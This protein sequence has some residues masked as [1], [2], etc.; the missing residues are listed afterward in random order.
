MDAVF[1]V[2]NLWAIPLASTGAIRSKRTYNKAW[3]DNAGITVPENIE[4]FFNFAKFIASEDPD[5]NGKKDSYIMEYSNSSFLFDFADIFRAFGCYTYNGLPIA[6]NPHKNRLENIA[7]SDNFTEAISFIGLLI[8]EKLI[9]N[10]ADAQKLSTD[11][12]MIGSS[13]V[14]RLPYNYVLD[15]LYSYYL[16]GL[17]STF[18]VEETFSPFCL[19]VL[20]Y[21]D[22]IEENL[23]QFF[24]MVHSNSESLFDLQFGIKGVDYFDEGGYFDYVSTSKDGSPLPNIGIS[25]GLS[26]YKFEEKPFIRVDNRESLGKTSNISKIIETFK[27]NREIGLEAEQYIGTNLSYINPF[28]IFIP[29]LS[30]INGDVSSMFSQ[31]VIDILEN[32]ISAEEVLVEYTH[33]MER[34]TRSEV[35]LDIDELNSLYFE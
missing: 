17:N 5:G 3:L 23:N 7:L 12:Y 21:S 16:K 22:S 18:L 4:E 28:T 6:F 30:E 29:E 10:T 35:I 2:H 14:N 13:F 34:M 1:R 9:I 19:A 26:P 31:L 27:E 32:N 20:K 24:N 11:N 8:D 33:N 25:V 15:R